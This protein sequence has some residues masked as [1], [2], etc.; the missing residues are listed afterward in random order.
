MTAHTEEAGVPA[1]TVQGTGDGPERA[2]RS[3]RLSALAQQHGALV[4]LVIAM[5]VASLSFDTFLT[6][7]NLENMALSSAFLAV[8]ALGMTFVIVTGGID[9]S[10]GS[11]F[12]LGGVLAA[13]G[14]RYGTAVALLLPLAVCG[15]VGLVNGLLIARV[16]LAPFIVTLAAMLGARGL[17]LA[18]TDEGSRT[19][20]VDKDSFFAT[21]GQGT[22]LGVGVPVWITLALFAAGAVVL[23]R[24]RFGQY[25]YAVGGN[26][27]AGALMGAPVARTKI[28]VYT[29]SGLCAGLAGALNAAWLASGVTILGTGMELDA[30]SAVVIGG[31]LLTGGSGFISGS[32]VGVLLLKVIQ[33][34]INQIGS[35][36]SAYQQVVSGAFLAVVVIAQTWLGRRRRVL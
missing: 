6:G 15:L 17:L 35:L 8:V 5:V 10:V 11:L 3:E 33:N 4:T 22:L 31:T 20:L 26:E 28:T 34:V 13:W 21:L 14:S 27:D 23:R 25:V 29:L 12:A 1:P 30:I 9:L 16:R 18:I 36:D 32:L 7:D 19:Y 24:S 2:D